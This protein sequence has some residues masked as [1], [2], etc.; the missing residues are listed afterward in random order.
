[1]FGPK[2][3]MPLLVFFLMVIAQAG[4]SGLSRFFVEKT[5]RQNAPHS[6]DPLHRR[7]GALIWNHHDVKS[8]ILKVVAVSFPGDVVER[9]GV[10]ALPNVVVAFWINFQIVLALGLK[11]VRKPRPA[12]SPERRLHY[13]A[14]SC[15]E[16]YQ[17]HPFQV[18]DSN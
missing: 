14:C 8:R 18:A 6:F 1:M 4:N 16:T 7:T 15:A 3:N 11:N 9:P 2:S 17:P 12:N 5:K 13:S 10:A